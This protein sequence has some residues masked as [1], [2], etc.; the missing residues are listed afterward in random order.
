MEPL[1]NRPSSRG[2]FSPACG[3]TG[4][5]HGFI[6]LGRMAGETLID[7]SVRG[8]LV[9]PRTEDLFS[10][11]IAVSPEGSGTTSFIAGR[12]TLAMP[13]QAGGNSSTKVVYWPSAELHWM[14]PLN[15]AI[16]FLQKERPMPA[17][18]FLRL[19]L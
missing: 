9:E 5:L 6:V 13:R 8:E 17:P 7:P 19:V 12:G 15:A 16:T 14:L 10:V 11:S 18:P 3:I 1:A 4:G 2:I